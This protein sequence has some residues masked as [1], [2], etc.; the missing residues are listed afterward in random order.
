MNKNNIISFEKTISEFIK[1]KLDD[2]VLPKDFMG[3]AV[4][5]Y[6]TEYGVQCHLTFLM[7]KPFSM[8]DSDR[9]QE[10][11]KKIKKEIKEYFSGIFDS[12]INSSVSTLDTY[13]SY[14][15]WYDSKK[16]IDEI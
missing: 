1:L 6:N 16:E 2:I 7:K 8:T 12:C 13:K 3:C 15:H 4:D 11:S 5:I 14:K 9:L 10:L